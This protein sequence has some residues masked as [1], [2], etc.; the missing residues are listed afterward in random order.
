[1]SSVNGATF[2]TGMRVSD[3]SAKCAGCQS[4][5]CVAE[6]VTR[7]CARAA[8]SAEKL[9]AYRHVVELEAHREPAVRRK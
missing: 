8:S 6:T 7:L 3:A 4:F 2:G 9:H 1:M 5:G